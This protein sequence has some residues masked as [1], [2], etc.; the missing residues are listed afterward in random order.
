M[1][2]SAQNLATYIL[3]REFTTVSAVTFLIGAASGKRVKLSIIIQYLKSC[4]GGS[5]SITSMWWKI[6]SETAM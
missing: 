4:D 2:D 5:D 3:N 6:S 1:T